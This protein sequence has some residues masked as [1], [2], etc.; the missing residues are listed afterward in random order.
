[1]ITFSLGVLVGA[2]IGFFVCALVRA[3]K[4]DS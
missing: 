4:E 3:D 1:M 2:G